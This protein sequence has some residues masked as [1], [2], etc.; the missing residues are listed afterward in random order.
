MAV[1]FETSI[2]SLTVHLHHTRT[3]RTCRNFIELAK[4]GYYDGCIFHRV[5]K[6]FMCQ[7]GDPDPNNGQGTGGDSIYGS[8]FNDEI[9]SALSHDK[10]GIVS[11]ANAG[12]NTNSSQFFFT[13]KACEHLDGK[14][15]IFGYVE[16]SDWQVLRDIEQVKVGK[17]ERPA[18]PIKIFCCH[19]LEDP[20]AGQPLPPGCA[21]PEKPLVS[22]DKNCAVQ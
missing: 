22:Q 5:V 6:G 15:T 16:E 3:P 21:I 8:T 9:T 17:N 18:K 11:M 20:W 1:R 19:I 2:G 13:F 14:H 7:T 12:L 4:A 10:V